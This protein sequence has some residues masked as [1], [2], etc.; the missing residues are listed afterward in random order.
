MEKLKS[1]VILFIILI[2]LIPVYLFNKYLQKKLRPRE[3]MGRLFLYMFSGFTIIFGYTFL[4]V[5]V[6]KKLFPGA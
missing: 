3:S 2:S 4:L 6:I 1:V 5:W